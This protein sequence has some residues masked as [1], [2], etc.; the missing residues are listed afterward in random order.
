MLALPE[1]ASRAPLGMLLV[2]GRNVAGGVSQTGGKRG[3]ERLSA[4][5][6]ETTSTAVPAADM[7]DSL[8]LLTLKTINVI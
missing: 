5:S 2:S 8:A 4:V 3:R 6:N 1:A 7:L